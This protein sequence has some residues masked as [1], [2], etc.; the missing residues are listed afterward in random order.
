MPFGVVFH[1]RNAPAFSC[2][3]DN[4]RG[5]LGRF[6][7]SHLHARGRTINRKRPNQSF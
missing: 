3:G 5:F 1:K 4:G 6:P 2:V 7:F